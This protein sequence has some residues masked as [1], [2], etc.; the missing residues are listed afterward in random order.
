MISKEKL[1]KYCREN[2]IDKLK[3]V[4]E[5]FFDNINSFYIKFLD[6]FEKSTEKEIIKIA[7]DNENI[8]LLRWYYDNSQIDLDLL[9]HECENVIESYKKK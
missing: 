4:A 3:K 9:E 1:L 5:L 8:K 6:K 7:C 2:R